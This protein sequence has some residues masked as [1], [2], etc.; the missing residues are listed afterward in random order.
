MRTT[1]TINLSANTV[2]PVYVNTATIDGA[3]PANP[4]SSPRTRIRRYPELAVTDPQALYQI[5]DAGLMAHVAV[6][7]ETGQPYAVPVAYARHHETVLFHGSTA[8]RLFR[9][10]AAGSPVCF[11]VTLLD[12]LVLARSAYESS[13]NYRSVM[14][15]GHCSVLHGKAKQA[16]LERISEH[17]MP[18]RWKD[19]RQPSEQELRATA[20]LELPLEECSAKVSEG[21]PDDDERDLGLPIWAGHVPLAESW[22]DPVPADDLQAEFTRVPDYIRSWRR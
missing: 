11:T 13:M 21:G 5:L 19:I 9:L 3:R 22:S 12:G 7:D 1:P 15:L 10:C 14:V 18:G 8:S 16:A 17:L 2:S 20:V 4:G 6:T